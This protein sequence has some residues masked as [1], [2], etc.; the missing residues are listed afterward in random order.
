MVELERQNRVLR[1]VNPQ[2][3]ESLPSDIWIPGVKAERLQKVNA[4]DQLK[5]IMKC[6]EQTFSLE[7]PEITESER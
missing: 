2:D 5:V 1:A 3:V 7:T 6:A 4:H